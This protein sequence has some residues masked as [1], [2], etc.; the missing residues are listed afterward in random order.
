[1]IDRIAQVTPGSGLRVRIGRIDG[2][3]FGAST[4]RDVVLSDPQG[5][6]MTVPEVELDWRPLSWLHMGSTFAR[7]SFGAAPV[8]TPKMNPG[9]PNAPILPDFD[10]RIDRFALENLTVAKGVIGQRRHIDVRRGPISARPGHR[11]CPGP[12]GRA[13]PPA[14]PPRQRARPRPFRD[15]R[16]L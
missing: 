14:G 11:R 2:S 4:L 5:R 13:R 6:F 8:R 16:R 15:G 3:L 9:D 7:W 10:I 1:V 12:S